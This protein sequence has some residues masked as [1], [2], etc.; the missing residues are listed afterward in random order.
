M[1]STKD[2]LKGKAMQVEGEITDDKAREA[3]GHAVE[4][5]GEAKSAVEKAAERLDQKIDELRDKNE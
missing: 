2:K 5:K 4:K 1:S 3:Q